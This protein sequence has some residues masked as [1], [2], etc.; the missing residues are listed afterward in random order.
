MANSADPD[1]LASCKGRTYPGAAGLGLILHKNMIYVVRTCYKHLAEV[2]LMSTH[3]ICF[4]G[5]VRKNI[6]TFD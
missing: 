4:P 1:Q 2:L 3:S 5:E 6:N